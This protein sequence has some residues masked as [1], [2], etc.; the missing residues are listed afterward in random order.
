M[1]EAKFMLGLALFLML[2]AF[3]CLLYIWLVVLGYHEL[4]SLKIQ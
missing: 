4:A 3:G 1:T 2:G